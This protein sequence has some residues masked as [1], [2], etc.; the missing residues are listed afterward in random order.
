MKVLK[1]PWSNK[2]TF[3]RSGTTKDDS[4]LKNFAD[5]TRI[6]QFP[7]DVGALQVPESNLRRRRMRQGYVSYDHWPSVTSP[8]S[9]D[10]CFLAEFEPSQTRD[11]TEYYT[12]WRKGIAGSVVVEAV[13]SATSHREK[14]AVVPTGC[15]EFS[16][17]HF[18]ARIKLTPSSITGSKVQIILDLSQEFT[19]KGN[20]L[21][22]PLLSF[23]SI[24]PYNSEVFNIVQF[25]PISSLRK[26]LA[27]KSA[28]LTD[29]DPDGRSLLNVNIDSHQ[30][31]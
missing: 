26:A 27:E 24:I 7:N 10:S 17:E 5:S 19:K 16:K 20:I 25:E 2:L 4:S 12:L 23:R 15:E 6:F 14:H 28:S 29:C 18:S 3:S 1:R 22:T 31:A 8:G 13:K 30:N 9:Q 21:L 11:V